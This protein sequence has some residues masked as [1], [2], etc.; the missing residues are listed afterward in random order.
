MANDD[1]LRDYL[2]RAT[3]ELQQ[4]KRRLRE[5][6]DQK[7]EPVAIV[8]MAC[9]YPGGVTSPEQLWELIAAGG[10]GITSFP[11]NRGWDAEA[12]YDPEPA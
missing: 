3:G 2:K 7:A 10:D 9:R 12:L 5:L 8:A 11:D 1:R 6:E 4:A